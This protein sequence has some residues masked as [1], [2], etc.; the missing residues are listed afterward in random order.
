MIVSEI[1]IY[2][3]RK[4]FFYHANMFNADCFTLSIVGNFFSPL[5]ALFVNPLEIHNQ[6]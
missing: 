6:L 5:L 3:E 1:S 2:A 4:Q